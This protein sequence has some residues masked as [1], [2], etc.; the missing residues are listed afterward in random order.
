[1]LGMPLSEATAAGLFAKTGSATVSAGC[2][3][4][5]MLINGTYVA[6]TPAAGSGATAPSV[7]VKG[8]LEVLVSLREGVV[9]MNG[10]PLL[11]TPEGIG[12]GAPKEILV[13]VYPQLYMSRGMA[14]VQ[15]SGN[16][17]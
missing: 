15:V 7:P 17:K 6:P 9:E 12:V 16:P 4:Y 8:Q 2:L 1:M 10:D 14:T 5:T 13:Q 11:R 3:R